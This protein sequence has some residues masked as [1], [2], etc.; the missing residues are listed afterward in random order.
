MVAE[1]RMS[2][3]SSADST[4]LEIQLNLPEDDS[5]VLQ[6]K[7]LAHATCLALGA[8]AR[9]DERLTLNE[10]LAFSHFADSF[11]RREGESALLLR[12]L[13]LEGALSTAETYRA[14]IKRLTTASAEGGSEERASLLAASLPMFREQGEE[15]WTVAREF[16]KALR[17]DGP[18]VASTL[19]G[20]G[21]EP[22]SQGV[23]KKV[24]GFFG[25]NKGEEYLKLLEGWAAEHKHQALT[26]ALQE[27]REAWPGE[28]GKA[29]LKQRVQELEPDLIEATLRQLKSTEVLRHEQLAAEQ[30]LRMTSLLVEQARGRLRA[31]RRRLVFENESFQKDLNAFLDQAVDK[32]TL[33]MRKLT[34]R[35][36]WENEAIWKRFSE[37]DS[38]EDILRLWGHIRDRY[39]RQTEIWNEELCEFQGELG[40]YV[41]SALSSVDPRAFSGLVPATHSGVHLKGY[42]DK[43]ANATLGVTAVAAFLGASL[44]FAGK[45]TIVLT[46]LT[47][48]VGASLAG[49][50]GAALLWKA[51]SD[52][53][54]RKLKLLEEKRRAVR[55]R[56]TSLI[57]DP[58]PKQQENSKVVLREFCNAVTGSYAP[59]VAC[60]RSAVIQKRLEAQAA[61][62]VLDDTKA[63]LGVGEALT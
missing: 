53:E 37:T 28:E 23:L 24:T 25:R 46:T 31:V 41:Q 27:V 16:A 57:G 43:A 62:K 51:F 11:C 58:W 20:L 21:P 55:E 45:G 40:T 36:D 48:P 3:D 8:L 18:T 33:E 30:F 61:Q 49:V 32:V 2:D 4:E 15:A 52:R 5:Q 34:D 9:R 1:L 38:A 14:A 17:V 50:A 13:L 19:E 29:L 56:L 22:E 44:A 26:A 12:A 54:G 39:Q 6:A 59:L 47:N 10:F 35:N 42:V 63:L 60:A 7:T